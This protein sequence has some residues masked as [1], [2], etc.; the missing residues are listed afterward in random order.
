ML[1]DAPLAA[2]AAF[3]GL[4]VLLLVWAAAAGP[5]RAEENGTI[6]GVFR[7][8]VLG[9]S[10]TDPARVGA[11]DTVDSF[12]VDLEAALGA[13]GYNVQVIP[14]SRSG[15]EVREAYLRLLEWLDAGNLPP[16]AVIVALGTND[17][18]RQRAVPVTAADLNSMLQLLQDLDVG[19]LLAGAYGNYPDLGRGFADAATIDAFEATYM[20]MADKHDALLYP[21]F[22]AGILDGTGQYTPDNLHP[23]AAGVDLIVARMLPLI[24]ALLKNGG[25]VAEA[26]AD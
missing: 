13:I 11:V 18:L 1:R 23:N 22:L 12:P 15:D 7:L 10:L 17:A 14:F 21:Y 3:H 5:A 26:P 20:R 9:D 25:A 8:M 6:T 24:E 16:D 4:V 2:R 19:I